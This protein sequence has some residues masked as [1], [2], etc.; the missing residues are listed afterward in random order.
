MIGTVIMIEIETGRGT[1]IVNVNGIVKGHGSG[2]V[3]VVGMEER[4]QIGGLGMEERVARIGIVTAV[5]QGP[6]L[7]MVTGDPLKVQFANIKWI[8]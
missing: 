7:D 1:G 6:L 4:G 3:E 2:M 8:V 5:G